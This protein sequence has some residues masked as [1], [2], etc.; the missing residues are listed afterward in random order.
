MKKLK[1]GSGML[2]T[3]LTSMRV[4]GIR[5]RQH[6][7]FGESKWTRTPK[8]IQV[9]YEQIYKMIC[10]QRCDDNSYNDNNTIEINATARLNVHTP[11]S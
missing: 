11:V 9:M 1:F 4:D 2:F 8:G 7:P 6:K 5:W 10:P 3:V